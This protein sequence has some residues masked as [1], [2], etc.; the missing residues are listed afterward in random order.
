[1]YHANDSSLVSGRVVQKKAT[2]LYKWNKSRAKP[3]EIVGSRAE[4][5]EDGQKARVYECQVRRRYLFM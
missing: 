4:V 1:M 2:K 3:G 5:D